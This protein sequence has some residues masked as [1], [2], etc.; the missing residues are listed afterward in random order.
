MEIVGLRVEFPRTM[1]LVIFW[2]RWRSWQRRRRMMIGVDLLDT[3]CD[4]QSNID[5]N[6][7]LGLRGNVT[8]TWNRTNT[9][10]WVI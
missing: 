3:V 9:G 4:L 1:S 5:E 10:T 8:M 6:S 2:V 7:V